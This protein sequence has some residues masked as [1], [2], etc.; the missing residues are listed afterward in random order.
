ML[1]LRGYVLDCKTNQ[2]TIDISMCKIILEVEYFIK[3]MIYQCTEC[4]LAFVN[5]WSTT[6]FTTSII[7]VCSKILFLIL[8]VRYNSK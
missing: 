1:C 3:S 8:H 7:R 4:A 6:H 5:Y 2:Y